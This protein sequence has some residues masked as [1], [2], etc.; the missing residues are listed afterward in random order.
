MMKRM[1]MGGNK[2][3]LLVARTFKGIKDFDKSK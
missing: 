1:K 2:I 3:Q